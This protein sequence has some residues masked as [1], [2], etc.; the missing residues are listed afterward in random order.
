MHRDFE[1][2][3]LADYPKRLLELK[4]PP[5]QLYVRGQ[6]PKVLAFKNES[7]YL[8]G[9]R[10]PLVAIVGARR[11]SSLGQ[12]LAYNLA[13]ELATLGAVIISGG[14][15][16]IDAASH[17]GALAAGGSTIVV[18]PSSIH[19]PLPRTN[20]ALF[21]DVLLKGGAL[22]S[23]YDHPPG[24]KFSFCARNRIVAALCELLV[25][26]EAKRR[27]GTSYTIKAAEGLGRIVCAVPWQI[28]DERGLGALKIFRQGGRPIGNARDVFEL[29]GIEYLQPS[30]ARFNPSSD[31]EEFICEILRK[32]GPL[33][34]EELSEKT[35]YSIDSISQKLV[36]ME[37]K[38]CLH[39]LN[40]GRYHL[41]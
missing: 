12:E 33:S 2:F 41:F 36:Q 3:E 40:C 27:S 4:R 35:H 18:L 8:A 39:R 28:T 22:L 25:V 30:Q 15:L 14:A 16:G 19:Q 11:A 7:A 23:E 37:L 29:L 34:S 24:G 26:V 1:R 17:R 13:R 5:K 31:L 6:L 32:K 9:P 21:E 10:K 20:L 38:A